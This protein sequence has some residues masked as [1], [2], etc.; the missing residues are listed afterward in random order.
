TIDFSTD[1]AEP[2][3]LKTFFLGISGDGK[4][5]AMLRE[6][7]NNRF[8]LNN[9]FLILIESYYM[10][11]NVVIRPLV[12]GKNLGDTSFGERCGIVL[13]IILIAGTNPIIVDQPEDH[14]DGKYI[15][16][17]LVPLLTQQKVNRQIILVTRDANIAIGADSELLIILNQVDGLT[18]NNR[19]TIE[20]EI[21]REKY[22][23]ELDGGVE[24]FKL[25]RKKY[26]IA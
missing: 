15:S 8:Q 10:P 22:I 12:N 13:T 25:R 14:L 3:S 21:A 19:G 11:E 17:T 26:R 9:L 16:N 5:D 6:F 24:A 4:H 20:D 23:W 18:K 2:D 1:L 7:A